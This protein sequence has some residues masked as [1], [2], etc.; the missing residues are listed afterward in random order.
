M[1][2]M[3]FAEKFAQTGRIFGNTVCGKRIYSLPLDTPRS[4]WY[5]ISGIKTFDAIR[6]RY[7]DGRSRFSLQASGKP[8][9]SR[10]I[11]KL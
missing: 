8:G 2:E 7:A 11:T 10:I 4:L 5:T 3:K 6:S 9:T 1:A